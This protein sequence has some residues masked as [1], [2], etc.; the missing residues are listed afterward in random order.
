MQLSNQLG[1]ASTI[2]LSNRNTDSNIFNSFLNMF[3]TMLFST[4]LVT[5][6]Q[7]IS[8]NIKINNI[9]N[10]FNDKL[11]KYNIYKKDYS[12]TLSSRRFYNRFGIHSNDITD[13][14]IAV[15][16]Y[17]RKN[18]DN[19]KGLYKLEQDFVKK[20]TGI[21]E[22]ERAIIENYYN[23]SQSNGVIIEQFK[24][25]Y[26]KIKNIED[27][28]VDNTD[29]NKEVKSMKIHNL[30]IYSNISLSYIKNF[31]KKCKDV[32]DFDDSQIDE[33]FIY[34]YLG[35]D[36][37]KNLT[38]EKDLFIPYANFESLVGKSIKQ[39][40]KNFDFFQSEKGK[41][42]Y[43][44]RCLPYQ[45]THLYYGQP[46]TGKS[47]IAS[48]IA[49]KYKLNIIKIRLS[50]IKSNREFCRVFKNKEIC[51]KTIDFYNSLF[52]FDEIDIELEKL[53][54]KSNNKECLDCEL[55]KEKLNNYNI[56]NS[57][58][59]IDFS[60][61]TILEEINGINQMY[62]RKMIFITNNY[63]KLKEIHNGALI[64]PGRIDLSIE[65]KKCSI[66]NSIELIKKFFPN[67]NFPKKL[68]KILGE[69]EY[70][71]AELS[72]LCKISSCIQDISNNIFI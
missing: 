7:N 70:T 2:L 31:I 62:G 43:T 47:I 8:N 53:L 1:T 30:V 41:N 22:D 24:N 28:I 4:L 48:A 32:K 49:N 57:I 59:D 44:E 14:K 27:S 63:D 12:I 19:F 68:L 67:E 6:V 33:Q 65:F 11:E 61:G 39:I 23:I 58:K 51:G 36:E 69:N 40:E 3:M 15:L 46:G 52:L 21:Y 34:T 13:E 38:Y 10:Y 60:L 5:F 35:E 45:L 55:N 72:N 9:I 29:N 17:I 54:N 26:L 42:W 18:M 64:R 20:S 50:D 25:T 37:K 56:I 16:Y 71:P 66:E